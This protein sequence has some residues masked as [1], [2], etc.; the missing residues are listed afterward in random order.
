MLFNLIEIN[1]FRPILKIRNR[2]IHNKRKKKFYRDIKS[3]KTLPLFLLK[4]RNS[5]VILSLKRPER[6]NESG[7]TIVK[8]KESR[9]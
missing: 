2:K 4:V 7:L 5:G 3:V 1:S 9:H 8:K 6:L